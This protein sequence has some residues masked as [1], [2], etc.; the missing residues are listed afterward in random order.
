MRLPLLLLPLL[1]PLASAY[2]AVIYS[3]EACG[4]CSP[5]LA[6]LKAELGRMGMPYE[7]KYFLNDLEARREMTGLQERMGVPFR[8][9][10]HLL[11][12][13]DGR[14]LFEGHVPVRLMSE[15]MRDEAQSREGVVITQDSMDANA[16]SYYLLSREG[17]VLECPIDKPIAECEDGAGKAGAVNAGMQDILLPLVAGSERMKAESV[18]LLSVFLLLIPF[19]HLLLQ[20]P[21]PSIILIVLS[22]GF[23]D[24]IHPCGFAVLLF[25]LSLLFVLKKTRGQMITIGSSFILGVFLAYLLIGL[26]IMG[27]LSLFGEPHL[28]ARLGAYLVILLGLLNLRDYFTGGNWFCIRIPGLSA[29]KQRRWLARAASSQDS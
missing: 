10:G 28:M 9:R 18:L 27:T 4:H 2:S 20:A 29:E 7:E 23:L 14:Y 19:I 15:F 1:M 26:G 13:I 6:G 11:T 21:D 17:E 12:A 22:S 8:M 5:Y 25:F 3:S 16:R 24:G